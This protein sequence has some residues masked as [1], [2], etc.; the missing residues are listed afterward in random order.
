M[1]IWALVLEDSPFFNIKGRSISIHDCFQKL[2][3]TLLKTNPQCSHVSYS[4][5][6]KL[7]LFKFT[8]KF[9]PM[10]ENKDRE[11]KETELLRQKRHYLF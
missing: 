3:L 4:N 10:I 9:K 7:R 1:F 6:M 5:E 8:L 11:S 2:Y